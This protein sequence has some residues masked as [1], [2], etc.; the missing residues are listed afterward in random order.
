MRFLQEN[1]FLIAAVIILILVAVIS[2]GGYRFNE[3]IKEA[4][5]ISAQRDEL[6]K[7]RFRES[8]IHDS[9]QRVR[10]IEFD[11]KVSEIQSKIKYVPYEKPV[12]ILYSAD[13]VLHILNSAKH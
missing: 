7:I 8:E 10:Q 9:I 3:K 2:W 11:Q 4:E 1:K 5:E 6:E 12:Y 13:S